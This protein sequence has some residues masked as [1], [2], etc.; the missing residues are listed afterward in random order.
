[1]KYYLYLPVFF[2]VVVSPVLSLNIL[3]N[4]L[5]IRK[6]IE[7]NAENLLKLPEAII[8]TFTG[9]TI[10]KGY[11]TEKYEVTTEDGYILNLYRI[12]SKK[13]DVLIQPP[14]FLMHGLLLNSDIWYDAGHDASLAYMLADNCHDLWVGN[15]RG[16]YQGRRHV[17]L[18]PDTDHAFW[19]YCVDDNGYYDIPAQ[20]DM[21]LNVT[22][23]TKLNYIGYSQGCA[24]ISIACVE[25][26][27]YCNKVK[28]FIA[29][30]PALRMKN[31]RS[32]LFRAA[33][34]IVA[35][36]DSLLSDLGIYELLA[37]GS[38]IQELLELTC[39]SGLASPLCQGIITVS[40][41]Y[42]PGSIT[43]ATLERMYAHFPAG[44][45]KKT[46]VKYAQSLQDDYF[47][48][49]NYGS[50]KNLQVYGTEE[51]PKFAL[52]TMT[53]PTVL[54]GGMNDHI[55]DLKD[56]YWLKETLPNVLELKIVNSS[57]WNHY[58][59]TYSSFA[60]TLL[61]PTIKKYLEE[62]STSK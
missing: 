21:V 15:V 25:R 49:Y 48:K 47:R 22:Q 33:N 32:V 37:K 13:C 57:F 17:S 42:D 20:I 16:S 41:S 10:E 46:F 35:A 24:E 45:S 55:V 38:I 40:D 51:A 44:T 29:L 59:V 43:A 4:F 62:Y 31:T 36:V 18:N 3:N 52:E 60:P 12:S 2:L 23:A 8:S 28:L 34:E 1:M 56:V 58:D 30:A 14:V 6:T 11:N 26:P 61:F 50:E 9:V 53:I 19:D 39:K 27:E 54:V 5:N 7:K